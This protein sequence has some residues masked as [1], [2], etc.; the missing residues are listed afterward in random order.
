[1]VNPYHFKKTA[2][3]VFVLLGFCVSSFAQTLWGKVFDLKTGEPLT[4]A[5]V[6]VE[7]GGFKQFIAVNLDGSYVF[8]NLKPGNY[9]VQVYFI[10]YKTTAGKEVEVSRDA[11]STLNI[12]MEN[13]STSLVEVMVKGSTSKE[14]DRS[15][16]GIE[17]NASSIE[18]VLSANT[19]QLLPDV[20]VANAL[21]RVKRRYRAAFGQ[22]RR[23]ICDYPRDGPAV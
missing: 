13:A 14:T 22:R 6:S 20:T 4:G 18:N 8:R 17:K 21:Q 23:Q 2:F 1:M 7:K 16:R 9:Q 10:G 11:V 19:I 12:K 3:L 15:A 5:S